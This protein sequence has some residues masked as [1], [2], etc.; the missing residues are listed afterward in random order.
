VLLSVNLVKWSPLL[1]GILL[2]VAYFLML[3]TEKTT[4]IDLSSGDKRRTTTIFSVILRE[5]ETR[6]RLRA[7]VEELGFDVG[8]PVWVPAN[9]ENALASWRLP[10]SKRLTYKYGGVSVEYDSAVHKCALDA[11][12]NPAE[13]ARILR[14]VIGKSGGSAPTAAP[15]LP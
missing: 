14:E 7:K 13:Q 3:V 2:A 10:G 9:Q 11:V 8:S 6:G 4:H 12:D 5:Q 15:D 1:L